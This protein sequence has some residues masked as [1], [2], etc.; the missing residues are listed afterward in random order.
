MEKETGGM[1]KL[2]PV[3]QLGVVVKDVDKTIDY[4]SSTYGIGPW[5]TVEINHPEVQVRDKTHFWKAKLAFASMG[6]VEIELIQNIDG[7][8]IHS[9]FLDEGREGLHHLDFFFSDEDEMNR[10]I[11]E[12]VKDGFEVIQGGK[13]RSA[14]GSYAYL[15]T[16]KVAGIMFEF[17]YR[18]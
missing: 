13:S 6:P 12:L 2:P 5:R 4:Y 1:V 7:R 8:S 10:T 3:G 16:D 9:E 15:D 14:K 17:I 11:A 18:E